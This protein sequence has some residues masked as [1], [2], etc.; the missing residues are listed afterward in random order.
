M[1]S[2]N[3]PSLLFLSFSL[4]LCVCA[5]WHIPHT[6]RQICACVN[7]H[8]CKHVLCKCVHVHMYGYIHLSITKRKFLACVYVIHAR[9]L[10]YGCMHIGNISSLQEQNHN[11][12]LLQYICR[13]VYMPTYE[14]VYTCLHMYM[15]IHAYIFI[16]VYMPTYV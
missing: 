14:H 9:K 6:L 7:A 12:C 16:C 5:C 13:C 2:W 4:S 8:A 3:F 15:N 10:K 1:C 11:F